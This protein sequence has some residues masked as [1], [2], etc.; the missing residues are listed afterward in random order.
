MRLANMRLLPPRVRRSDVSVR[1]DCREGAQ[2]SV[3]VLVWAWVGVFARQE[4]EMVSAWLGVSAWRTLSV[5]RRSQAGVVS[6][7]AVGLRVEAGQA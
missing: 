7:W 4:L 3:Q 1:L 6:G 5:L 2:M